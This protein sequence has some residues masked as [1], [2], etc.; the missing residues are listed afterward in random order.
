MQGA[1]Y[2]SPQPPSPDQ[3][4]TQHRCPQ[5]HFE[6][7]EFRRAD[8]PAR[9]SAGPPPYPPNGAPGHRAATTMLPP[10]CVWLCVCT[11]EMCEL[12]QAATT[13]SPT[14]AWAILHDA[15]I[16]RSGMAHLH[17]PHPHPRTTPYAPKLTQGHVL[18]LQ[19]VACFR[20]D[21]P[22]V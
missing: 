5:V 2:A 20:S 22:G 15:K 1:S 14:T 17:H 16:L 3:P 18:T 4:A 6:H 12:L 8:L 10:A 19:K 11:C 9:P 7:S 21:P 13:T